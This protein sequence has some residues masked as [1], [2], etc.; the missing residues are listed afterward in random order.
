MVL[1]GLD[2]ER[3]V[4]E[5]ATWAPLGQTG[6]LAAVRAAGVAVPASGAA[7]AIADRLEQ[8]LVVPS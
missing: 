5:L 8:D 6:E 1:V 4:E 2:T 7:E 3:A